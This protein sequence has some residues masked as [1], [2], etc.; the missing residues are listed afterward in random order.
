MVGRA[1]KRKR[2]YGSPA[3]LSTMVSARRDTDPGSPE[4]ST[5]Q[6]SPR[7]ACSAS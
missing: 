4:I 7:F 1:K 2:V 6:P 3:S 5:T